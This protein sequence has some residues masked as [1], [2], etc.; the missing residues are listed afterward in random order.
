MNYLFIILFLGSIFALADYQARQIQAGKPI[1]HTLWAAITALVIL[2]AVWLRGWDLWLGLA[3]LLCRFLFF[4]PILNYMRMPPKS[5]FYINSEPGTGSKI[6]ALLA[7]PVW[8]YPFCWF[9]AL[10]GFV[11]ILI[12]KL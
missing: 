1:N 12:F 11:L 7:K 10:A 5:F 9:A 4:S 3:C 8:L 2:A 6:D